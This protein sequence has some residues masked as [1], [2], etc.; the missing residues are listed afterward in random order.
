MHTNKKGVRLLVAICKAKGLTDIIIS[1]GSRNAPL[2]IEFAR[3]ADFTCYVVPDERSA[4]FVALGMAQQTG[5]LTAVVCTSG[6]APLNYAPA[7]AEAYYQRIPLVAITADRPAEW[8]DQADGQAL[9][10]HNI[11]EN[12][13][14]RSIT[15]PQEPSADA[16]FWFLQRLVAETL[17]I[18]LS[19]VK[20]PVHINVPLREPLYRLE[21]ASAL[22]VKPSTTLTI[23]SALPEKE[24]LCLIDSWAS[25]K[26]KMIICGGLSPDNKISEL[27]K[28]LLKDESVIVLT[29]TTSNLIAQPVINCID[30]V[31][32]TISSTEEV[33]FSPDLLITFGG[34]VIS[35]KIK[36]F[37]R[38]TKPIHHWHIDPDVF[39][40]DTYQ[41]LTLHI[42]LSPEVFLNQLVERVVSVSSTYKSEWIEKDRIAETAHQEYVK[43]LRWSDMKVFETI[44]SKIPENSDLQMGN[45][46]PVRYTQLFKPT[47]QL[48]Y[49]GNR[50]TSGIDGCVS[51]A[52]GAAI[53]SGN[54]T[55]LIIGDMAFFYD[56]NGLWHQHLSANLRI[57]LINNGG[58]GIFRIIEGPS[59]VDE[60]ERFFETR[61][62][63][64]APHIAAAYNL[65]YSSAHSV[66]ELKEQL[67]LFFQKTVSASLLE[68][69]TP[70]ED[71]A[72]VL[73]S[74]FK[75]IAVKSHNK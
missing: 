23:S 4:A 10:Q 15:L 3:D 57:I 71:N 6:T 45:S 34:P 13:V 14:R 17:D 67:P 40:T 58:G 60:L 1:P 50:G 37:I 24:L 75:F 26:K 16:D 52:A 9:K 11:F 35:K 39:H 33:A 70:S 53:G 63:F 68:I 62:S 61:H 55:T 36:A 66:E 28:P 59:G 12:Y 29:E 38:K 25:C 51:T 22:S 72:E 20:G 47:K 31:L 69:F 21:E 44:L 27:I 8:I 32:S 56:T 30:R 19:D 46:T 41:S 18:A 48:H 49:F 73:S 74:Y 64:T 54:L 5:R 2:V 43:D 7:L 65:N 42:P